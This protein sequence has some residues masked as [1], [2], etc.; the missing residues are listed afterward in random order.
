MLF[1][2]ELMKENIPSEEEMK[3][4]IREWYDKGNMVKMIG[5]K[6]RRAKYTTEQGLINVHYY[7]ESVKVI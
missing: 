7:G 4:M 1:D 3:N 2:G 5:R 6:R